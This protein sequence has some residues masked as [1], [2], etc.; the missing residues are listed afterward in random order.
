MPAT[1]PTLS[2]TLSAMVAGFR[3]SSSGMPAS[4]LPTRS[5]PTSA[6]LVKI[7]P[8]RRAKRAMEG[9]AQAESAQNRHHNLTH[10]HFGYSECG[11]GCPESRRHPEKNQPHDTHTDNRSS[12][13]RNRKRGVDSSKSRMRGSAVGHR[14][15]PHTD[16]TGQSAGKGTGSGTISIDTEWDRHSLCKGIRPR[17]KQKA[18][19]TDIPF[20]GMSWNRS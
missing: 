17:P 10:N 13:K 6:A 4:T 15:H 3:G 14:R 9:G 20:S 18:K 2:P 19:A 1:S 11:G 7:P 5:A 12:R 16:K 8:P